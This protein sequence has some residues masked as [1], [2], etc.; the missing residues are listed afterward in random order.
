M[1][2]DRSKKEEKKKG[3]TGRLLKVE[4]KERGE[5]T[6]RVGGFLNTD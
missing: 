5:E 2:T 1:K 6:L 4:R 3:E